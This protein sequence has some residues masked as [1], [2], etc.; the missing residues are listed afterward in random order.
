MYENHFVKMRSITKYYGELV[1][2]NDVEFDVRTGEVHALVGE[3]GAGKST[4][5]NILCGLTS[6]T[7]GEIIIDGDPV[8]SGDPRQVLARGIVIVQQHFAVVPT[9]SVAQNVVLGAE[10]RRGPFLDHRDMEGKVQS[11]ISRL[12]VPL[13]PRDRADELPVGQQQMVEIMKGLYRHAKCLVLD[14]PTSAL[15]P[16][17]GRRLFDIVG[18]LKSE[19]LTVVFVT[20]RISEVMAH[21]D[22]ATVLCRGRIT[23]RFEVKDNLE[24]DLVRAIVGEGTFSEVHPTR[25]L[26]PGEV[27]LEGRNLDSPPDVHGLNGVSFTLRRREIVGVAGVLGNGQTELARTLMGCLSVASGKIIYRGEDI[28][29]SDASELREKG[30]VWIPEDRELEGLILP[31]SVVENTILGYHLDK[32]YRKGLRFDRKEIRSHAES[33]ISRFEVD[34]ADLGSPIRSLSGGNRQKVVVGRELGSNPEFI[35]AVQPTRGLDIRGTVFVR[36]ELI[37]ARDRG[38]G[39]MLISQDLEEILSLSDRVL[40]MVKGRIVADLPRRD[41]DEGVLGSLMLAGQNDDVKS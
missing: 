39:V 1:A 34:A 29:G 28:T 13:S 32:G 16:E 4:L 24:A 35:L 37:T 20:H 19:G 9:L 23:G 30:M 22:R 26:D 12:G 2:V 14:E 8:P 11:L 18:R 38:S 40:V 31:F 5:V 33:L 41:V 6:P 15:S 17:E 3:N 25:R 36:Q 7:S 10:P 27:L 21:A